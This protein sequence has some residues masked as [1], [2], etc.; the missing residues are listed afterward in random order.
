MRSRPSKLSFP[1]YYLS[2]APAAHCTA[3][4]ARFNSLLHS[5]HFDFVIQYSKV[6]STSF[7]RRRKEEEGKLRG[8][9]KHAKSGVRGRSLKTIIMSS[10]ER[11]LWSSVAR[12]AIWK[13]WKEDFCGDFLLELRNFFV[14]WSNLKIDFWEFPMDVKYWAENFLI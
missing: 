6:L 7:L 8:R 12:F 11:I 2:N 5:F 4:S 9:L 3:T 14:N 13:T 10:L 1:F